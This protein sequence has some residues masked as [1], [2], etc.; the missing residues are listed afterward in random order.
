M[1]FPTNEE[2]WKKYFDMF[3]NESVSGEGHTNSLEFYRS[4]RSAMDE[5]SEV[6]NPTRF[7]IKDG[8]ISMIQK[9]LELRHQIGDNSFSSEYQM[10]PKQMSFALNI[11]PKTVASRRCGLG[12]LEIPENNVVWI[13]ASSDLNMSKYITTTITVFMRD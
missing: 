3:D 11:S 12:K 10:N 6:F 5:G 7:S 8:H 1:Q 9:L 13:C 2:L 4:N